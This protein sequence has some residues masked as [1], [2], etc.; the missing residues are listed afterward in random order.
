MIISCKVNNIHIKK[1]K[2]K[3][4]PPVPIQAE[5]Q[6]FNINFYYHTTSDQIQSSH[7]DHIV[8]DNLFFQD[9]LY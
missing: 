3:I 2:V 8:V 5:P 6:Y 1:I 4:P 7:L 9:F